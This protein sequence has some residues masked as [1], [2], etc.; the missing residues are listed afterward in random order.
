MG[1]FEQVQCCGCCGR[2]RT[3]G[4]ACHTCG[5][6]SEPMNTRPGRARQIARDFDAHMEGRSRQAIKDQAYIA[7]HGQEA[8]DAKAIEDLKSL[9]P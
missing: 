1:S 5:D 3:V 9:Y 4:V 8:F 6:A 7:E 2:E